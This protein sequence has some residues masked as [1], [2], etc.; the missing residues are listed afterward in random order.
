[1]SSKW[2]QHCREYAE[3]N[4]CTYKQAMTEARES[5]SASKALKT[6]NEQIPLEVVKPPKQRVKK[7]KV[8][9]EE[10]QVVVEVEEPKP[11]RRRATKKS[12]VE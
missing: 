7:I 9:A 6:D 4:G 8:E 11:K 10:K 5:Y 2:I 1:M 12:L 3:K